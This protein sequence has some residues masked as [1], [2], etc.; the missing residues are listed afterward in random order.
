MT[1]P[2]TLVTGGAGFIGS[3]VVDR[4]LAGGDSVRVVD[5]LST[6]LRS[7]LVRVESDV[8]LR[9]GCI[10]DPNLLEQAMEGVSRVVHLAALGSVPRSLD[11][12]V[13][14]HLVNATGTLSVLDACRKSGSVQRVV[15]SSSSSVYGD[16]RELPKL[17]ERRGNVLSPY[18]ASKLH[19][20]EY[21]RLF[22]SLYD[23]DVVRLR[24]FNVFGPRQRADH[25]YAAVIPRFIDAA[26][27]G[28]QALVHGDGLQSRDFTYVSNTVDG[29]MAVLLAPAERVR[30]QAY[31][32]ACGEAS[33]LID[34]ISSIEE[35]HG[36]PMNVAFGDSRPGD[37]QHSLADIGRI[38]EDAGY[39]PKVG[40][41]D[42]LRDTYD[43]HVSPSSDGR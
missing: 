6:G 41:P 38:T 7:N 29:I 18:A 9:V 3:H 12:P 5:D 32:L 19:G 37:V 13:T 20:E 10:T 40:V 23:L 26:I 16:D 21:C 39:S 11:D 15:F 28:T 14:T 27:A 17:E 25:P 42:G 8:D 31:N 33:T 35:I 43:W 36:T 2:I 24:F 30:G 4:L 34:L 22:G 1:S